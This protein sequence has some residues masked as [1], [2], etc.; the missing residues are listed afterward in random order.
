MLLWF[1][2]T[3]RSSCSNISL[4]WHLLIWKCYVFEISIQWSN[5]IYGLFDDATLNLVHYWRS[6]S[7]VDESLQQGSSKLRSNI[8]HYN[9]IMIKDWLNITLLSSINDDGSVTLRKSGKGKKLCRLF[10]IPEWRL[11]NRII[12]RSVVII[13][14]K[15]MWKTATIYL[16]V[17]L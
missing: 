13:R 10:V 14:Q 12:F 15:H 8:T 3:C 17:V 2:Y 16:K 7:V 11:W 4:R 6:V 1:S 5:N 9:I